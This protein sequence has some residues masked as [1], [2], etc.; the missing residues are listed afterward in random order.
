M[1]HIEKP[2]SSTQKRIA[3]VQD[4]LVVAGGA[5]RIALYLSDIFPTAPI[6]TSVYLP[7]YTFPGLKDK[8]IHTLPFASAIKSERQFKALFPWWYLAF[9]RLDLS[10]YDIIISS[11]N[12]LAKY[13][14]PPATSTHICYLNN[15]TRILWKPSVYSGQSVPFGNAGLFSVRLLLPILRKIDVKKTQKIPHIIANSKNIAR[16]IQ[17][18]YHV[19]AEVIYSPIDVAAFSISQK[20]G[21]YY[22]YVG[23]LISHKHV[24]LAIRACNQL[25]RKLIIAGDGFERG[26]LEKIAG[27]SV[28]FIGRATDAQLKTLYSNCR[29]L[30]FPSDEDFGLV[31]VEAQASGRPVIAYRSGGALETVIESQ[32]GVFFDEQNLDSIVRAM[33]QFETMEFDPVVIRENAK[34]F[35]LKS[36]ENKIL[37]YIQQ[38]E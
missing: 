9:S 26:N 24:D 31:P 25:N 19:T 3:I 16:Q 18:I 20:P 37:A 15:P 4:A 10:R 2:I 35:D 12:Y 7:E 33:L 23:R 11:G 34:R 22:L 32:T 30:L 36:F 13:I 28:Q 29:A 27:S 21:E 8:E 14:N 38:F 17:E 6:F 1:T 5:E